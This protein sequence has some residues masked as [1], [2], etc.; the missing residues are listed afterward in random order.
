VPRELVG[1]SRFVGA[2]SDEDLARRET[3]PPSRYRCARGAAVARW[4]EVFSTHE[5]GFVWT[6]ITVIVDTVAIIIVSGGFG[7]DRIADSGAVST[8]PSADSLAGAQAGKT[9]FPQA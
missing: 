1:V 4:A 2:G 6:A 3:D 8:D 7:R 9:V 5:A